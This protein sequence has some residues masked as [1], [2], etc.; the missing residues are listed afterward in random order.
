MLRIATGLTTKT[1]SQFAIIRQIQQVGASLRCATD[2]ELIA[3][4]IEGT[5]SAVDQTL[6]IL[7]AVAT[8]QELRPWEISDN[9]PR[10][11]AEL[12]IRP[13]QVFPRVIKYNKQY[14]IGYICS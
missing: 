7:A 13:P 12:S 3:Y 4:T 5:R 14:N 10:A 2:R 8:Q 11:R 9:V 1:Y 6:P